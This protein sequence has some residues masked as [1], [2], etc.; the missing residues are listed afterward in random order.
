VSTATNATGTVSYAYDA[1]DRLV[2]VTQADGSSIAYSYDLG[3][4]RTSVTTQLAAGPA[5]VTNYT[6]DALNRIATV[7]DPEGAVTRNSYDEIGNLA[8]VSY[9]NGVIST[10]TYDSL[11]RLTLL[12]HRKGANV[13]A[14]Y[15]YVVN[16]VG[17]RT[18]VTS[19]DSSFVDYDYDA[20]RQLTRE[21]YFN[22][23]GA[24][25]AEWRYLYDSTGNRRSVVD[26]A[27]IETPYT[28]DAADKLLNAGS[29]AFAYDARGNAV[30]RSSAAGSTGYAFNP[31]NELTRVEAPSGSVAFGYDATGERTSTQGPGAGEMMNH[32]VDL[33]N[34][35]GV[36]QV[37]VDHDTTGTPLAEYT[38]GNELIGQRRGGSAHYHHRDGSRN[39]RLLSDSAGAASDTYAYN[40]FG[41]RLS[42]SGTTTNPYQFAGDRYGELDSLVFLR[43]R[44][45]DPS[46]G[47][48][49]SK[50]PF[51]GVLRDPVSLHRYLYANAN[52]VSFVDP[53]GEFV[54]AQELGI[55]ASINAGISLILSGIANE[56]VWEAIPKAIISAGFGVIGGAAGAR[57]GAAVF[58]L[59]SKRI[60][61]V[62][63]G[64]LARKALV[65]FSIVFVKAG[66]STFLSIVNWTADSAATGNSKLDEF[67]PRKIVG[68]F[69]INFVAEGLTFGL[70][71]VEKL[72]LAHLADNKMIA[73][74]VYEDF[75]T[76]GATDFI[77]W[78]KDNRS[79]NRE[80]GR[81]LETIEK[82]AV[83]DITNSFVKS[84]YISSKKGAAGL[85]YLFEIMKAG[86]AKAAGL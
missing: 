65:G 75:K 67:S 5:R 74:R 69:A 56:T 23:A 42:R 35:S 36:S 20:R 66:V 49:I 22:P 71:P 54:T 58:N 19:A 79:L 12:A 51:E 83:T 45:Y 85:A 1:N 70:L 82:Y 38:Y 29:T 63:V 72:D 21:S 37:L 84:G 11:S 78:I 17:D 8:S 46:T 59:A 31:E 53:T 14:S 27:G 24:K 32:L 47:R 77:N 57:A 48:F 76:S 4:N 18:R 62:I 43:A 41:E 80:M 55:A 60:S 34:A 28:Y 16:A 9:P 30:S 52:P 6:F 13:I 39:V 86:I 26:M 15:A 40:A 44:Y 64:T 7:T 73:R 3:G 25:F 33:T 68:T 2:K 50:D 10:Y 61:S 81:A